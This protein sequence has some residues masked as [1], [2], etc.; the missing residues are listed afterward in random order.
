MGSSLIHY[1]QNNPTESKVSQVQF[2]L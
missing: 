1:V 2:Q